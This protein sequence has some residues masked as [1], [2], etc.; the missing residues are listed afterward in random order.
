MS[1]ENQIAANRANAQNSTGPTIAEGQEQPH[2][3]VRL[4]QTQKQSLLPLHSYRYR[5][6]NNAAVIAW[7]NQL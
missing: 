7:K 4:D 6:V 1:S 2:S 5:R 3:A